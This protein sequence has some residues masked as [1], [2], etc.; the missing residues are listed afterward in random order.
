M[1]HFDH[2]VITHSVSLS[3][4]LETIHDEG[5][6]GLSQLMTLDLQSNRLKELG[7]TMFSHLSSLDSLTL[8]HNELETIPGE[9]FD[10]LCQLT[11]LQL[12]NNR[13]KTVSHS[14]FSHLSSLW[15]LFLNRN[16]LE[17]IPDDVFLGLGQLME[18]RLNDNHLKSL[19]PTLVSHMS[20]LM[21]MNLTSNP[22]TCDCKLAWLQ[23]TAWKVTVHGVCTSPPTA[24]DQ[25]VTSYDV[26]RC[27]PDNTTNAGICNVSYI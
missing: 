4:F 11:W 22:L 15:I 12:S 24:R 25:S 19:N 20:H 21:Y 18:L 6:D 1:A 13:L 2:L 17:T 23:T 16:Q 26:S 3:A 14:T 10:G 5:F 27:N 7:N 9:T 8:S